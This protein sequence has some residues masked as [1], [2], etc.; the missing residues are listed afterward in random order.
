MLCSTPPIIAYGSSTRVAGA[1]ARCLK[2]LNEPSVLTN[3][4]G[5]MWGLAR[6]LR[7]LIYDLD[8]CALISH[9]FEDTGPPCLLMFP[10]PY[11][12]CPVRCRCCWLWACAM[13]ASTAVATQAR[14]ACYRPR[15]PVRSDQDSASPLSDLDD[16][17]SSVFST[18]KIRDMGCQVINWI[19]T[20]TMNKYR[21]SHRKGWN[22]NVHA[23]SSIL[24]TFKERYLGSQ[25]TMPSPVVS[26]ISTLRSS[27]YC[28]KY[29]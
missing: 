9:G 16:D 11:D 8:A 6:I 7:P 2:V 28:L 24:W 25:K 15:D 29:I 17:Q 4:P 13:S 27:K 26:H 12:V 18:K 21:A 19:W 20:S 1:R 14:S 3:D 23:S 22:G 5:I 10:G